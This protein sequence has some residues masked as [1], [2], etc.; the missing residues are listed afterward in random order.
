VLGN[1]AAILELKHAGRIWKIAQKAWYATGMRG[2]LDVLASVFG[3]VSG[4]YAVAEPC[5]AGLTS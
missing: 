5:G 4:L 3:E 2:K 1:A